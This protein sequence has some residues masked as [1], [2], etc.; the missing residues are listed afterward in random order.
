MGVVPTGL[1]LSRIASFTLVNSMTTISKALARWSFQM[2]ALTLAHLWII[3]CLPNVQWWCLPMVRSTKVRCRWASD[4]DRVSTGNKLLSMSSS[5]SPLK[6]VKHVH[7]IWYT[8]K[9][10]LE[11]ILEMAGEFSRKTVNKD[12]CSVMRAS[13]GTTNA[14]EK[15]K[16]WLQ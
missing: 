7:R 1:Q 9:V 13:S 3:Q 12:K 6:L 8:T 2:E 11:M 4:M 10:S 5:L 14:T 16:K 15:L